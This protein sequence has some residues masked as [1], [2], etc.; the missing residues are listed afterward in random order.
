M[1]QCCEIC[2]IKKS[3]V[4]YLSPKIQ[5]ELIALLSQ[6]VHDQTVSEIKE[7]EFYSVIMDTTQDISK[8]D[9]LSQIFRYVT[10]RKDENDNPLGLD[11]TESFLGFQ[12]ITDQTSEGLQQKSLISSKV[13][14]CRLKHAEA[15]DMTRLVS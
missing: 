7:A 1:T 2:W 8:V 13:R 4:N 12:N 6:E 15:R 3:H 9:Q 10:V 11:V 5:N 14:V